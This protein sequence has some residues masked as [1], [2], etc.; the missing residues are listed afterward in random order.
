MEKSED[1][2]PVEIGA[3][4]N[5]KA[6]TYDNHQKETIPHFLYRHMVV[7]GAVEETGREL[8]ILDLGCGTG[9]ELEMILA[10]APNARITCID[11]SDGMLEQLRRKYADSLEQLEVMQGSFLDMPFREG[12]Y[13]YVVSVLAMHHFTY[14]QKLNLY[15]RVRKAL[16]SGGMYI[17]DDYYLAP[18]EEKQHLAWHQQL[19]ETGT[20]SPDTGYHIDIP[21]SVARQRQVL[22]EVGFLKVEVLFEG[23]STA[24]FSAC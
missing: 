10:R 8:R 22:L 2:V 3:F 13:E 19:L 15:T 7:A 11:I 21:F 12:H 9:I 6:S 24:V 18:E 23:K 20:I 17:E 16:L 5:D 4:F 1:N 14:P